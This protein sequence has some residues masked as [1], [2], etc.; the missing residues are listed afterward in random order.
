M[1]HCYICVGKDND[2]SFYDTTVPTYFFAVSKERKRG[3]H[4]KSTF[5]MP[6]LY[7]LH[8]NIDIII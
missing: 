2:D 7:I 1:K 3:S 8:L 5:L 4:L 6:I